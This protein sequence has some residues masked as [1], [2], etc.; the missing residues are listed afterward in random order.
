MADAL[1]YAYLPF[2]ALALALM[3]WRPVVALVFV[4]AFFPLDAV[5]PRLGVP[6]VNTETILLLSALAVTI[7][8][9][10]AR[11]PPLRYSAPVIAFIV[12]MGAGFLL[13]VPWARKMTVMGGEPAIWYTFKHWKSATFSTLFFFA[14]YWWFSRPAD[15]QR[16]L[17][18]LSFG[19]LLSSVIALVDFV[20]PFTSNGA[21]GRATGLQGDPNGTA[22][23]IGM[24]MFASLYLVF[25]AP[26]VSFM[27]RAFHLGTYAISFLA[28]VLTLSRGNYVA[29]VVAHLVFFAL[30]NRGLL[31]A[32]VATVALLST[33]AFPLLPSVVRERIEYTASGGAGYRVAGGERLEGS[34][35][36]RLVLVQTGLDMF[37]TSPIW[38]RGLNFFFFRTPEFSAKYGSL[39]QRDAHNLLVKMAVEMGMIGVGVL[40][41]IWWA[42]YRCGRRLWKANTVD[43]R[44]GAVLLASGA[45]LL[46]ANFSTNAFI[47]TSQISSYFWILYGMSARGAVEWVSAAEAEPS[48]AAAVPRWRRFSQRA[49]A[50]V[51]QL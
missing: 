31:I 45:H 36:Q 35:A 5:S 12:V 26:D 23:A 4:A 47:T 15:R 14:S 29:L 44:L 1:G 25:W 46:V 24:A 38:G 43:Y 10:G 28:V 8:R 42:V 34:T 27:R 21:L 39:E 18:A 6:G 22:C 41:W 19:T 50:A 13:S 3:F 30:L 20:H 16:M 17:E 48:L 2:A 7:L 9:F 49:A 33:V 40:L 51:S 11:L 37:R 32:G